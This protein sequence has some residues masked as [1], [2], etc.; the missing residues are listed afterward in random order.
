MSR[1]RIAW[2]TLVLGTAGIAAGC[3]TTSESGEAVAKAPTVATLD[4]CHGYDCHFR[5]KVTMTARDART[6]SGYFR[7]A[8][9]PAA[10]RAAIA[11]AVQLFENKATK[12]I[13]VADRPLSAFL[14]AKEKGQMDCLDETANTLTL[15]RYLAGRGLLKHHTVGGDVSRGFLLDARYFHSAASITE[16]SGRRWAVDSWFGKAGAAPQIMPLEEWRSRGNL[17]ELWEEG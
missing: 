16:K 15:L 10:E 13:G 8:N 5:T 14:G 12:T 4:V 3:T 9:T 6:L 2:L 17:S 1:I 7:N 11:R